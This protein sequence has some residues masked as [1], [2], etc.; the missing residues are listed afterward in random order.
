MIIFGSSKNRIF[1]CVFCRF[2]NV[3][4][5]LKNS[6]WFGRPKH[7]VKFQKIKDIKINSFKCRFTISLNWLSSSTSTLEN[8]KTGLIPELIVAHNIECLTLPVISSNFL[9]AIIS[10]AIAKI[11]KLRQNNKTKRDEEQDFLRESPEI[12]A[13]GVVLENL[14]KLPKNLLL[15]MQQKSNFGLPKAL[16]GNTS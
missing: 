6:L 15:K 14:C 8:N 10:K 2:L 13:N 9:Q 7:K 5:L 12:G 16:Y 11:K 1:E 4:Y 3:F